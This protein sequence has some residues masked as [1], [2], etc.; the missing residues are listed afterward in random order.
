MDEVKRLG[1]IIKHCGRQLHVPAVSLKCH[2]PNHKTAKPLL[3]MSLK[4]KITATPLLPAPTP[5]A[6]FFGM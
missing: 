2:N 3:I 5:S 1:N 4:D 6:V